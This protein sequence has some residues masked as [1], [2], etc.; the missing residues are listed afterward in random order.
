MCAT[1]F[2]WI[3]EAGYVLTCV[4]LYLD[5]TI[6]TAI[7]ILGDNNLLLQMNV[8]CFGMLSLLWACSSVQQLSLHPAL[9]TV[10]R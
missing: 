4:L 2:G 10:L 9:A 1:Y 8:L 3:D 6:Y 7:Y 5:R